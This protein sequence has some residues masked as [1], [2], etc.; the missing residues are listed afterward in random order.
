MAVADSKLAAGGRGMVEAGLGSESNW[1]R[2]IQVDDG[3]HYRG[4]V[5]SLPRHIN[6]S[7]TSLPVESLAHAGRVLIKAAS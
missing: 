3:R 4:F 5:A 7:D 2:G 6:E 1:Q